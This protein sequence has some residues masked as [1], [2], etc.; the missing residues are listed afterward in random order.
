MSEED[1]AALSPEATRLLG[2]DGNEPVCDVFDAT[3]DVAFNGLDEFELMS[4]EVES[5]IHPL[6]TV[7]LE[8]P[9]TL[10][11]KSLTQLSSRVVRR[12][13]TPMTTTG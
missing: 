12:T 3:F 13:S 5:D 10:C 7:P 1:Q 6:T 2:F 11:N 9:S 8:R 4:P